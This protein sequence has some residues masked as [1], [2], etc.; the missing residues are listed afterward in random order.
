MAAIKNIRICSWK[1]GTQPTL[2]FNSPLEGHP[3]VPLK[4]G[5]YQNEANK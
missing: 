5:G 4:P 1:E 2:A 3:S